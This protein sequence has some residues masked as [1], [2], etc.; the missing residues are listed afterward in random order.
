MKTNNEVD[1]RKERYG[2]DDAIA[3]LKGPTT[4]VASPDGSVRLVTNGDQRLATAG[5][6]DVLAGIIGAIL[7][8][9]LASIIRDLFRLFFLGLGRR[10]LFA[11][12]LFGLGSVLFGRKLGLDG[13]FGAVAL[14]LALGSEV[15]HWLHAPCR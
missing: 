12:R 11:R 13:R 2:G 8:L 4:V 15:P 14:L 1:A 5:T 6:G 9:P 3:L 7:A 10:G